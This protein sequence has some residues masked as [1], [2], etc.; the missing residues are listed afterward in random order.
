[1]R[2]EPYEP[3]QLMTIT[4]ARNWVES[5]RESCAKIVEDMLDGETFAADIAAAIRARVTP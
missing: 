5:E 4:A 2:T 1:M 3:P